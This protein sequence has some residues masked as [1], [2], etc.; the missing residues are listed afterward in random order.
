MSNSVPRTFDKKSLD[1]CQ[2]A[3]WEEE[4]HIQKEIKKKRKLGSKTLKKQSIPD[5]F[6]KVNGNFL[7][8]IALKGQG[9]TLYH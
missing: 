3:L 8:T 6:S 2:Q 4:M 9:L 5:L 7:V 1:V